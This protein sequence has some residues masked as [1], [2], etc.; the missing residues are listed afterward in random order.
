[1]PGD[2]ITPINRSRSDVAVV[3]LM[4]PELSGWELAALLILSPSNAFLDKR[5]EG[6]VEKET[7]IHIFFVKTTDSS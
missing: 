2:T 3:L 4:K 1:M 6:H 5:S 7:A